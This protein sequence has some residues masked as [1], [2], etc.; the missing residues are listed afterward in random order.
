MTA[1]GRPSRTIAIELTD[2][3]AVLEAVS[4]MGLNGY[5]NIDYTQGLAG[6]IEG[7]PE[8]FA[9]I[10]VGTNSVKFR[11]AERAPDGWRTR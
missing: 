8:R 3:A 11:I 4:Q 6:I 5:L 2:Q 9:V 1:N 7:R 10:D